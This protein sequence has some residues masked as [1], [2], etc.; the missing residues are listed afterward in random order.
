MTIAKG[1]AHEH[2]DIQAALKKY[3]GNI[4]HAGKNALAELEHVALSHGMS[5]AAEAG[6]KLCQLGSVALQ[7]GAASA[8]DIE[9]NR[10]PTANVPHFGLP[11]GQFNF[12]DL[13][14]HVGEAA[15]K[16]V[17]DIVD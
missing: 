8:P 3:L 7:G 11:P 12:G 4:E 16:I 13:A 5:L 1:H 10:P 15:G 14:R 6:A 17:G 2:P 9:P